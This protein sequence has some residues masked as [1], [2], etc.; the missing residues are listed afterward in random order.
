MKVGSMK[1]VVLQVE[2]NPRFQNE[3]VRRV[4]NIC[5]QLDIYTGRLIKRYKGNYLEYGC[6]E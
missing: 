3:A 5:R 2:S 4:I 1:P 6:I